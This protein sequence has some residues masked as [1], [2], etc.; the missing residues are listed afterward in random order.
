[1]SWAPI[2]TFDV[3]LRYAHKNNLMD[4]NIL[5]VVTCK[6]D[7]TCEWNRREKNIKKAGFNFLLP[8]ERNT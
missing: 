6:I 5:K 7:S 8:L 2:K 4:T 3:L 1:M